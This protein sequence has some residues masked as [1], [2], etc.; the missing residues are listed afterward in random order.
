MPFSESGQY[1]RS[2]LGEYRHR[3]IEEF[4]DQ[5]T[6]EGYLIPAETEGIVTLSAPPI[7][8]ENGRLE[9]TDETIARIDFSIQAVKEVCAQRL[10]KRPEEVTNE[11]I[12]ANGPPLILN[13]EDEQL[14]VMSE[15]ARDLGFPAQKIELVDCGKIGEANTQTQFEVMEKNPVN[16]GVK[17]WTFVSSSYHVPR[18]ARTA[19]AN[20]SDAKQFDVI[21][22]PLEKYPYDIYRKIRGEVKRIVTYSD[23]GYFQK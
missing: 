19:L 20:L 15:I 9:K 8:G 5:L 2:E 14:P 11:D 4:R 3:L 12:I 17:H 18:V 1:E 10:G 13:G 16:A 23:K 6:K 22:V 21:G 7:R